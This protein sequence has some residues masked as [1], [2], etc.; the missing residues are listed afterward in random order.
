MRVS[1]P[2]VRP[3][4]LGCIIAI[5]HAHKFWRAM[6]ICCSQQQINLCCPLPRHEQVDRP[7]TGISAYWGVVRHPSLPKE[8]ECAA[9]E[10][11][12]GRA[13]AR[14]HQPRGQRAVLGRCEGAAREGA[15]RPRAAGQ[16]PPC[17]YPVRSEMRREME[18]APRQWQRR[19]ESRF[20]FCGALRQSSGTVVCRGGRSSKKLFAKR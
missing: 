19:N 20:S 12:H 11:L 16:E 10:L 5:T 15:V 4:A 7:L 8:T 2:R 6:R 13:R 18:A 17:M 14:A 9:P 1:A 3:A